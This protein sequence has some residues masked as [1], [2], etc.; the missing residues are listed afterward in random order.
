MQIKNGSILAFD[1][2]GS[3]PLTCATEDMPN[4]K[5]LFKYYALQRNEFIKFA[6]SLFIDVIV[7]EREVFTKPTSRVEA[8]AMRDKQLQIEAEKMVAEKGFTRRKIAGILAT[9]SRFGEVSAGRVERIL[10]MKD[11]KK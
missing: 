1:Y 11:V 8:T 2:E 7:G 6:N 10:K 9:D 3:V 4:Q 5:A